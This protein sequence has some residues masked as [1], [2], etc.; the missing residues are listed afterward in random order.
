MAETNGPTEGEI[1]E[2][3]AEIE[4]EHSELLAEKME[5]LRR[6]K[7]HHDNIKDMIANAVKIHGFD[8]V[9][10]KISIKQREYTRKSEKLENEIPELTKR[11]LNRIHASLGGK[12]GL[13]DTPLGRA[14]ENEAAAGFAKPPK[15]R[16]VVSAIASRKAPEPI[17][18][19]V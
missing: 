9:A 4:E 10:L 11:A 2:V 7:P 18:D 16:S 5:Y 17:S 6:C 3:I 8:K 1:A 15:R 19:A 13:E 14:A 12:K